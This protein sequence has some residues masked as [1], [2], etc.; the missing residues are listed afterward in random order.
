MDL[1]TVRAYLQE[2]IGLRGKYTPSRFA[3]I[4]D[5]DQAPMPDL[6]YEFKNGIMSVFAPDGT[7]FSPVLPD[8]FEYYK[9][10]SRLFHL[11]NDGAVN[12]FCYHR[13]KILQM[14][15]D[16]HSM[17][18]FDVETEQQLST[19]HRDFYN[20]RKVDTHIHHSAAMNGKHLLR[21]I[22]KKLKTFGTDV[23]QYEDGV[24]VTL[25]QVFQRLNMTWMDLSLDALNVLADQTIMHRFDRFNNKYSPLGDAALRNIFLKTDNQMGGRYLAEITKELMVDLEESKY[26][27]TEWRLSIYGRKREEWSMLAKWVIGHKLVCKNNQ[28]MIQVPRL[29]TV[30]KEHKQVG[31]FQDILDNIFIPLFNATLH[32]EEHPELHE[33]LKHVSGF[34]TVDDESKSEKPVQRNFSSKDRTPAEWDILD[35]PSYK[36]YNFYLQTNLRILNHLRASRGL[37]QFDYRPHAGEAGE[38]HHLDTAFLL[39]DNINHGINLRRSMG[40]QYLFYLCQIGL[41][42]SPV[43]NNQLFLAYDK[44]PFQDFFKRGLNVSL[45]TDDPLMFHYTKEPLMEEYS[46]ARQIWKLSSA[47][48][49]E[50]ARNSVLQSGFPTNVKAYWLKTENFQTENVMAATNLPDIR[51]MFRNECLAS[52]MKLL[53]SGEDSGFAALSWTHDTPRNLP[54]DKDGVGS[55]F[56]VPMNSMLFEGHAVDAMSASVEAEEQ[57]SL[58]DE[59]SVRL[60]GTLARALGMRGVTDDGG[61]GRF[62]QGGGGP[63]LPLRKRQRVLNG[64]GRS[65]PW[66]PGAQPVDEELPVRP[67]DVIAALED[68]GL[69]ERLLA[70]HSY[71]AVQRLCKHLCDLHQQGDAAAPPEAEADAAW[72]T[73]LR[74]AQEYERV[75]LTCFGVTIHRS[76]VQSAPLAK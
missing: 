58:K 29:Y 42:M 65:E 53:K 30:Y 48:M 16:V 70:E 45:S 51:H 33:F 55:P 60:S 75:C 18:N 21:F 6:R 57:T 19:T 13:L 9:D 44:H 27:H 37:S 34:D 28:W 36:Y 63:S 14:K 26:Q 66:T 68:S 15:F 1:K 59:E 76:V 24:G 61:D 23:V 69:L 10:M 50:L 54:K 46:I 39:A 11:R 49:C 31:C 4:K 17:V 20:T 25:E 64:H 74:S 41:A 62:A 3:T 73:V 7:L 40:L 5:S 12:T 52:E 8:V 43:S 2:A 32:P 67:G 71:Q 56:S 22:K 72:S 35:N 38:V 47:D